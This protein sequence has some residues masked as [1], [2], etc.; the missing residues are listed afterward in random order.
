M[1]ADNSLIVVINWACHFFSANPVP[2]TLGRK[3]R[4][5]LAQILVNRLAD[6]PGAADVLFDGNTV[7]LQQ[8]NL[9]DLMRINC[10]LSHFPSFW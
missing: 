6:D 2:I 8:L 9:F 5:E 10:F 4:M 3:N 7:L 1:A